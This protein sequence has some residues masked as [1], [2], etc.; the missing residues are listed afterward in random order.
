MIRQ[1]D[2]SIITIRADSMVMVESGRLEFRRRVGHNREKQSRMVA[3]FMPGT[4]VEIASENVT[5]AKCLKQPELPRLTEV[6]CPKC[7]HPFLF[8]PP[9]ALAREI[10]DMA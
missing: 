8:D 10:A 1:T 5:I 9:D 6:C 2:D 3:A 4:W 7:K